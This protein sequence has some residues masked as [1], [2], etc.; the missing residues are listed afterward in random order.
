MSIL[1]AQE[2]TEDK[3]VTVNRGAAVWEAQVAV[4]PGGVRVLFLRER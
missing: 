1:S 4:P 2:W 3:E